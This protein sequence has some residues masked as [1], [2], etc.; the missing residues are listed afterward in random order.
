M[1]TYTVG[2]QVVWTRELRGGWGYVERVNGRVVAVRPTRI[3]ISVQ[4]APGEWVERWVS[5]AKCRPRQTA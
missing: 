5:S 2:Q 1:S 4:R 3:Q